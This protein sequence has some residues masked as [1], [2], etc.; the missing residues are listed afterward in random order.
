[1][2][3]KRIKWTA[4]SLAWLAIVYFG[5]VRDIEGARN[6]ATIW[7]WVC[8]VLSL[9]GFSK[10]FAAEVAQNEDFPS[11]PP[12]LSYWRDLICAGAFA[13][14]GHIA[15]A[16]GIIFSTAMYSVVVSEVEKIRKQ[17]EAKNV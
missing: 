3:M 2:K 8:I 11:V 6:C 13:W 7:A 1:M 10:K 5:V 17:E 15:T 12:V 9:A 16:I 14:Y 4:I